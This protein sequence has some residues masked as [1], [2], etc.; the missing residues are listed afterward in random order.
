MEDLTEMQRRKRERV[1]NTYRK[2]PFEEKEKKN[3]EANENTL[4]FTMIRQ[5]GEPVE[6]VN[7]FQG[8]GI[9]HNNWELENFN[10]ALQ[11][12]HKEKI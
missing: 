3:L 5:Q 7:H 12:Q 9:N 1:T 11:I 6:K 2:T 4:Q 8:F 10:L